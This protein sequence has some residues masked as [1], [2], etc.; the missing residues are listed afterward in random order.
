MRIVQER[1]DSSVLEVAEELGK[2]YPGV[3]LVALG[4][5]VLWDEPVKAAL[6]SALRA[7]RPES[8]GIC[9]GINDHDY[10]SKTAAPLPDDAPFA[11]LEHNDGS[12][13]DLWVATGEISMLFGSETI[14]TRDLLRDHGVELE[15]AARDAPEG[16]DAF[17]D[18]ATAAW[19][20]RGIAE[21]GNRRRIAHEI[22]LREVLPYLIELVRW[23]FCES[24]ALLYESA[25]C[26]AAASLADDTLTW[27]RQYDQEN[28]E[29]LLSDAFRQLHL[30]FF[31]RLTGTPPHGVNTF[32]STDAFRFATDT[33]ALPRFRMVDLF[34]RPET[35][36][37][38]CRAYDA[39]VEGSQTYTLDRFGPGAIPFDLVVPGRGRGTLR[40]LDDGVAVVTPEP[41]WIPCGRRVESAAELAA[42]VEQ[43]L[44]PK[45]TLVGKGHVFVC[46]VT[47]EAI[48]VFHEGGS[49]YVT[50]TARLMRTLWEEGVRVPLYPILRVRH[51]TWDALAGSGVCIR[52]PDHLAEAFDT[53]VLCGA[54]LARR[55]R[56][57]VAE[58]TD[59]L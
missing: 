24:A 32:T 50:R 31:E 58:Q 43:N 41:L 28:P 33:V 8:L 5:T 13:R 6:F 38:A 47:A 57:V 40:V 46:M 19:G 25:A 49:A 59:L 42:L 7:L 17:I 21:T 52:L 54:E 56:G 29:A 23:A 26:E 34:L 2:R 1:L 22:R 3:P 55:W 37:L 9:I 18:R 30:R 45:V 44:G 16:H 15:K 20:W 4:Q 35:R 39:A 36:S 10:F 14:P 53:P 27:L 12:T 11:I 51:H 48:L